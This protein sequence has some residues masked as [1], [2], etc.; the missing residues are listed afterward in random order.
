VFDARL[1]TVANTYGVLSILTFNGADFPRY[2][3]IAV[4]EPS[5]LLS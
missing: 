2:R 4:L 3:N 5:S 1:A